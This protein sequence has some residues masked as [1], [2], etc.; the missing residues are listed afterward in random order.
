MVGTLNTFLTT[1]KNKRIAAQR[2][3]CSVLKLETDGKADILRKRILSYVNGIDEKDMKVRDI[4][5]KFTE[6][7]ETQGNSQEDLF[8]Q[9]KDRETEPSNDEE[10]EEGDVVITSA[11][12]PLRQVNNADD[13]NELSRK[14]KGWIGKEGVSGQPKPLQDI[15]KDEDDA[16]D[17]IETSFAALNLN[18]REEEPT[19][20]HVTDSTESTNLTQNPAVPINPVLDKEGKPAEST[21]PALDKEGKP[22]CCEFD[23]IIHETRRLIAFKD[24]QIETLEHYLNVKEGQILKLEDVTRVKEG[25]IVKLEDLARV[26]IKKLDDTASAVTQR[27]DEV[28]TTVTQKANEVFTQIKDQKDQGTLGAKDKIS[29]EKI[30]KLTQAVERLESCT[31]HEPPSNETTS[32]WQS[33]CQSIMLS[34]AEKM[35]K[36]ESQLDDTSQRKPATEEGEEII[37]IGDSNT[38]HLNPKMLHDKKKVSIETIYTLDAATKK[39]P[40]R[41]NAEKVTDIVFMTGLND[42]RD[43]GTSVDTVLKRQKQACHEYSHRFKNAKLHIASVAP[44]NPKQKNLNRQLKEYANSAGISHIDNNGLFDRDSG[45]LR[46]GMLD[47]PSLRWNCLFEGPQFCK[48]CTSHLFHSFRTISKLDSKPNQYFL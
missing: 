3:A 46:P 15:R 23:Q 44:V 41:K 48:S 36:I 42:S 21:H 38:K 20:G 27:A 34:M 47:L 25:Q 7:S 14:I 39:I 24:S 10:D 31:P 26:L 43:V 5:T 28:F 13:N 29:E 18:D 2:H 12:T 35:E 22:V 4:R 1:G 6:N 11:S 40:T 8:T 17:V 37:I 9:S 19:V 30:D 45:N 16:I 32:K 33:E